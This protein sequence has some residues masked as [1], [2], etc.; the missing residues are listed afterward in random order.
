VIRKKYIHAKQLRF[1]KRELAGRTWECWSL[2]EQRFDM[3]QR[4]SYRASKVYQRFIR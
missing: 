1:D 3:V 4:L 2:D